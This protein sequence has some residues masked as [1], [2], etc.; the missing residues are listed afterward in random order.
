MQLLNMKTY[1]NASGERSRYP[2]DRA[3]ALRSRSRCYDDGVLCGFCS[4]SSLKYTK[5]DRCRACAQRAASLFVNVALGR[6]RIE[7]NEVI[8]GGMLPAENIAE[9]RA[10]LPE[11]LDNE[12]QPLPCPTH[13]HIKIGSV[14]CYFCEIERR[15]PTPRQQALKAG[16]KTYIPDEPCKRCGERAAR[17]VASGACSGCVGPKTAADDARATTESLI[18]AKCPG[19][20]LSREEART[21]NMR[22]FRTGKP[23]RKGH[24]DFRYVSTGSCIACLR[25]EK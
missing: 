16:H 6:A 12:L 5:N 8:P 3:T 4:A 24:T 7:G 13:G 2:P 11:L 14:G 25:G 15:R 9:M 23:C 18:R 1:V 21:V 17:T 19:M 10:A 20:I 22:I